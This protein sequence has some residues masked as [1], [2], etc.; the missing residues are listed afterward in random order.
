MVFKQSNGL[1]SG[2]IRPLIGLLLGDLK[3]AAVDLTK[4][5]I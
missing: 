4:L 1:T 5:G 3:V 2:V